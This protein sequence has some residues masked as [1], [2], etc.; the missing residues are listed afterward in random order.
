MELLSRIP[1]LG[2]QVLEIGG[3]QMQGLKTS[4]NHHIRNGFPG[5]GIENVGAMDLQKK[6]QTLFRD[7]LH[8]E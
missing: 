8:D 1:P 7:I 2:C 6:G 3:T 4:P 5:V